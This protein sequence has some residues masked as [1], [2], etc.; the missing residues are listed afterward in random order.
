MKLST[1]HSDYLVD[2]WPKVSIAVQRV[3]R[4]GSV[5][6]KNVFKVGD[7][8]EYDSYNLIYTGKI[9]SITDKSVT[10][11][12]KYASQKKRLKLID[13]AWRN[14]DFDSAKV[15]AKNNETSHYI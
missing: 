9:V 4:D 6:P 15:A 1:G 14:Y 5:T 10:I 12:P 13:F 11:Q 8:A 2:V 7:E 3:E